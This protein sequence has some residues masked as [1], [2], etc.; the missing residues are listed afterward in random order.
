MEHDLWRAQI[1]EVSD[2]IVT[3]LTPFVMVDGTCFNSNTPT[4]AVAATDSD[5]SRLRVALKSG[6]EPLPLGVRWDQ[7]PLRVEQ[8]LLPGEVVTPQVSHWRRRSLP[9]RALCMAHRTGS[10]CRLRQLHEQSFKRLPCFNLENAGCY[11][12]HTEK[13]PRLASCSSIWPANVMSWLWLSKAA[14]L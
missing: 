9:W 13:Q 1:S 7:G 10:G 11:A 2:D 8:V 5:A 4:V 12:A 6:H 3:R 14:S